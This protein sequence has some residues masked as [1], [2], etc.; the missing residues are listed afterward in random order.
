[1]K[2]RIEKALH[3]SGVRWQATLRGDCTLYIK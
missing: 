2:E 1:M 3:F